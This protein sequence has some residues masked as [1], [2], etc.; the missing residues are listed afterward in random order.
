MV[1]ARVYQHIR[2]RGE[3]DEYKPFSRYFRTNT[4]IRVVGNG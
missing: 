1:S 2:K 3:P 4:E